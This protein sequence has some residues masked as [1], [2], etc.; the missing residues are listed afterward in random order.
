MK[1][2]YQLAVIV[3]IIS[4]TL[5]TYGLWFDDLRVNVYIHINDN[6]VDIGSYKA[7]ILDINSSKNYRGVE[8][9]DAS[10]SSDSKKFSLTNLSSYCINTSG[11]NL[12]LWI[13]LVLANNG[14]VPIN[15]DDVSMNITGSYSDVTIRKYYYG[16]YKTGLGYR[17]VW[18]NIDPSDLP[19][20]NNTMGMVLD[21]GWKG[22][23]WLS[24]NMSN[25]D[26]YM[27]IDLSIVDSY[28]NK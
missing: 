20:E 24:V 18:G 9:Q 17:D 6:S 10:I 11:C 13:G 15:I 14:T 1:Y 5:T 16:P 2:T 3:L 8:D 12:S 22:I 26:G 27:G 28:W 21:P 4:M 23:V 19:F 25:V 7:Y